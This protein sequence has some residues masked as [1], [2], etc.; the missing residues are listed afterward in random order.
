MAHIIV[1]VLSWAAVKSIVFRDVALFSSSSLFP[2]VS[3]I[4]LRE[5]SV[6]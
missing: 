2:D 1:E 3:V 5:F 4:F 6:Q